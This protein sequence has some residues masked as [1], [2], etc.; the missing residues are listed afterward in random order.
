LG[1]GCLG[2][3]RIGAWD[4]GRFRA[5]TFCTGSF[6]PGTFCLGTFCRSTKFCGRTALHNFWGYGSTDLRLDTS[7]KPKMVN[8]WW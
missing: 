5:G 6:W 4:L 1:L 8:Y 3:G 7:T 2:S